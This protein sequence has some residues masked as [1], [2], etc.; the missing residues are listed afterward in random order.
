MFWRHV[1]GFYTVICIVLVGLPGASMVH[2]LIHDHEGGSAI[3]KC[4]LDVICELQALVP[5]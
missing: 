4:D 5:G 3:L 1:E 2:G